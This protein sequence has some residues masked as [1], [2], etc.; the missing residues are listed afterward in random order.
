MPQGSTQSQQ[1]Y[2]YELYPYNLAFRADKNNLIL[3][4]KKK[5]FWEQLFIEQY[6]C[7]KLRHVEYIFIPIISSIQ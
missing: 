5:L 6:V 7:D 4:K 3:Q 2:C 1:I